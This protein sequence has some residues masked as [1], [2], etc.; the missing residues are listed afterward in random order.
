MWLFELDTLSF[1]ECISLGLFLLPFSKALWPTF[2]TKLLG[3][4]RIGNLDE[5]YWSTSSYRVQSDFD[6][7][8]SSG[9]SFLLV[10]CVDPTQSARG[11][12]KEVTSHIFHHLSRFRPRNPYRQTPRALGPD[13]ILETFPYKLKPP[14]FQKCQLPIPFHL[15][16]DASKNDKET[17]AKELGE[18]QKSF[19][20]VK[21]E[22]RELGSCFDSRSSKFEATQKEMGNLEKDV[23]KG[24]NSRG[25]KRLHTSACF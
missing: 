4:I 23:K 1:S 8:P 9:I 3:H 14:F 25:H 11:D 24:A 6:I 20:E 12:P 19:L 2:S 10:E 13:F 21:K 5:F 16:Q 7:L 15:L 17:S 22:R 18:V